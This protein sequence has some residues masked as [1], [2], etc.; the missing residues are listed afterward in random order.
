MP[1]MPNVVGVGVYQATT[2]LISVG[3]VPDNGLLPT[4]SFVNLGYFDK[5]PVSLTWVKQAGTP[6]GQVISQLPTSGTTNV[7]LNTPVTL[8]V[9]NF[10][11]SVADRYSAGGYT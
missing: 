9:S 4:G 1:T 5:W 2:S 10:P 11:F 3:I 7:V 8:T 6:A